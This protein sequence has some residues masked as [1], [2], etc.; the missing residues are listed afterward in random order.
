MN[1][2]MVNPVVAVKVWM[3]FFGG[4]VYQVHTRIGWFGPSSLY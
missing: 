3:E 4:L 1:T 2:D